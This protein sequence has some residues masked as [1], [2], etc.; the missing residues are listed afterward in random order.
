MIEAQ[1]ESKL[2]NLKIPQ[3]SSLLLTSNWENY[4]FQLE[5]E[6]LD[7][8]KCGIIDDEVLTNWTSLLFEC[9]N[10]AIEA[11]RRKSFNP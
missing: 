1:H 8:L 3:F 10:Q 11:F 9:L 6:V 5:F 7:E 2:S 4:F